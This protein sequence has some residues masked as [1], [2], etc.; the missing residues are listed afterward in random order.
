MEKP[1]L[2][3]KVEVIALI[4]LAKSSRALTLTLLNKTR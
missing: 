1:S 4:L 3:I 2:S